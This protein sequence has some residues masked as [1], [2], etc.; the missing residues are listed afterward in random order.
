MPT[1]IWIGKHCKKQKSYLENSL[2]MWGL[3]LT[4]FT[5]M[6]QV[7]ALVGKLKVL[8]ATRRMAGKKKKIISCSLECYRLIQNLLSFPSG[9]CLFQGISGIQ[10]TGFSQCIKQNLIYFTVSSH[11]YHL[12]VYDLE[13]DI[14]VIGRRVKIDLLHLGK[15]SVPLMQQL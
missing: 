13:Q 7:Q 10:V 8:Q 2:V 14:N 12:L 6:A 15:S 11:H 9:K 3:G 1:K 5:A 4:A